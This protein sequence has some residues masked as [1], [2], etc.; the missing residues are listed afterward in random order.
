MKNFLKLRVRSKNRGFPEKMMRSC[1]KKQSRTSLCDN[2]FTESRAVTPAIKKE[3]RGKPH[4]SI[5]DGMSIQRE[6]A[7]VNRFFEDL[8]NIF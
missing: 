5:T 7:I 4:S 1:A 8:N 6:R 3:P 2:G